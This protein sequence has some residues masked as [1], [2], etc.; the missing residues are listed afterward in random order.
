[1]GMRVWWLQHRPRKRKRPQSLWGG[2]L[3]EIE[4]KPEV[5]E[6][7]RRD[8]HMRS[9]LEFGMMNACYFSSRSVD[10]AR[11]GPRAV[12]RNSRGDHIGFRIEP[13]YVQPGS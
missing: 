7:R 13:V 10:E 5:R 8:E 4:E 6:A 12:L 9:A 11:K 1:M 3:T 2:A